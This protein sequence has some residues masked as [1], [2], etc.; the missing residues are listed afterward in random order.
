VAPTASE[1]FLT[2]GA[3]LSAARPG[4]EVRLEP[5][6]Y[7]ERITLGDGVSLAAR[8]PGSVTFMRPPV[9]G[10]IWTAIDAAGGDLGGRLSGIRI[11]STVEL[12]IDVGIRIAG[13]G[14]TLDLIEMAGP[15]RAG[16][17]LVP[18]AAATIHG[19]IFSVAGSALLLGDRAQ[20]SVWSST[21]LRPVRTLVPPIRIGEA[22][23]L[24]LQR[25]VF[26]GY[27][28]ELV[29]GASV[30]DRQ[31]IPSANVIVTAESSPAR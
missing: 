10:E 15:M 12:P 22:A 17:E 24:T 9:S 4:D 27:D 3:G 1:A 30:A 21:F 6:T 7:A 26:A 25:N 11:E 14:R 2:L 20:V 19:G 8:V 5:G 28:A 31:Q 13:Q 16:V 23:Q 18:G 29:A